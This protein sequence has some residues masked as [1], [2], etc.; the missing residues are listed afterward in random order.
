MHF[1]FQPVRTCSVLELNL[2]CKLTELSA[3]LC[4]CSGILRH[5]LVVL[6]V[7]RAEQVWTLQSPNPLLLFCSAFLLVFILH[8]TVLVCSP[9]PHHYFDW[10]LCFY[11]KFWNELEAFLLNTLQ[12]A[13]AFAISIYSLGIHFSPKNTILLNWNKFFLEAKCETSAI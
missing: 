8:C 3:F 1:L 10:T 6:L 5:I 13:C 4:M 11:F 2:F 9:Y 7:C 12:A